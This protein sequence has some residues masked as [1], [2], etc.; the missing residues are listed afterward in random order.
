M[1]KIDLT[2]RRTF[3]ASH[4]LYNPKF[5]E[6]KNFE[7][8]DKCSYKNGHGHNYVVYV[9]LRG[10]PD[11][12]T[13]M[14]MNVS[15]IKQ[16]L[17]DHVFCDFDHKHLNFDVAEFAET[18]RIPTV[19]LISVVIWER[20]YPHLSAYLYSIKVDETESI[21]ATYYGSNI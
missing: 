14:L 15:V 12:Q 4:R 9:T 19:E 1:N 10:E 17:E 8:F 21:S 20:L 18:D 11:P 2:L 3:C 13:G 7:I 6:E 5:S 16:L